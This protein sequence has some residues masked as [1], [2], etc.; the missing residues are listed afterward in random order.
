MRPALAD[1][2]SPRCPRSAWMVQSL[3]AVRE[4]TTSLKPK[5]RPSRGCGRVPTGWRSSSAGGVLRVVAAFVSKQRGATR[6]LL[7]TR[8][9]FSSE[10][11]HRTAPSHTASHRCARS[12]P[13]SSSPSSAPPRASP[14]TLTSWSL[15]DSLHTQ[16]TRLSTTRATLVEQHRTLALLGTRPSSP[17]SSR[18]TCP[19]HR[20]YCIHHSQS[21][22]ANLDYSATMSTATQSQQDDAR[23]S[24]D[25]VPSHYDLTIRTDLERLTFTG[26]GEITFTTSKALP[27]LTL[28]A[29]APLELDAA[30][31]GSTQ[32]KTESSRP[33][34]HLRV[35]DK[36]E[37]VEISF[38]G[39]EVPAGTHKVGLRWKGTLDGPSPSRAPSRS[40]AQRSVLRPARLTDTMYYPQT[41]C[42]AT[43]SRRSRRRT[44]RARRSTASPN[45]S[46]VRLLFARSSPPAHVADS[47]FSCTCRP[48]PPCLRTPSSSAPLGRLERAQLTLP[49][50][51]SSLCSHATA[52]L[53]RALDEGDLLDL[54][55]LARRHRL[56]RQ[57][58]G[59]LDQAPRLGRRLPAH[60]PPRRALLQDRHGQGGRRQDGQ[61]RGRDQAD[62]DGAVGR[63]QGCVAASRSLGPL[64][65]AF[66]PAALDTHS[67]ST[68]TA[69]D[70]EIT[71]F[72]KTPK[73][74]SYLV[75]WAN[76]EFECVSP[77][78]L[79]T[80]GRS[81]AIPSA[82][83][84]V[85]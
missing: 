28:H 13:S 85:G 2:V 66:L 51:P 49:R 25:V 42:S 65:A 3:V 67:R 76:G 16:P 70:W 6:S 7:R 26:T 21:R 36:K 82:L 56:A 55:H 12:L 14:S 74:S 60:R 81:A 37:R 38:E 84:V 23:L 75:A 62:R 79:S 43:T 45:S 58:R 68:C 63:V 1:T 61:D 18:A 41:R 15:V 4:S 52:R 40:R 57:H 73:V 5:E 64:P 78:L 29:A 77:L 47:L 44:A 10:P 20:A 71:S 24:T 19:S 9:P 34:K 11:L 32:V 27:H 35:L 48:G 31:L 22:L 39:G 53:R 30:V 33:A 17:S 59:R 72:A 54:A 83:L 80:S 46:L 50:L 8:P 69:D